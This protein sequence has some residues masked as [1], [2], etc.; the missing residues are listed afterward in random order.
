MNYLWKKLLFIA[1]LS[2]WLPV[3]S[4]VMAVPVQAAEG[5]V[6]GVHI[7]HPSELDAA[8]ELFQL[9]KADPNQWHYVT[10]PLSLNDLE[11]ND[12]WQRFFT[13]AK[14]RQIIPLVRLTTRFEDGAWVAPS[15]RD[16]TKLVSFL[17]K[18]DWPTDQRH[19]I[20]FNE[21]NHSKEWGNHLSPAE[22]AEV[23][24]FTAQWAK[25]ENKGFVV[26]PAAMDL[27][28]P[29]GK[30]TMEAFTYLDGM[31]AADPEIFSVV[32]IWN[33]HSYPNPGFS[34]A[35]TRVAQNSLRGFEY[36]L[37]YVKA[38]SGRDLEVFITET[39]WVENAATRRWLESYYRY[40]A[41]HIWSDPRVK[42]VTP[43]VLKG[44]PGPFS[45]F[46]LLDR[47][48]QPTRQYSAFKTALQA[49]P[50]GS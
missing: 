47:N 41:Q 16:I 48:N 46:S 25:T 10:I 14:R 20:V 44:D 45:A 5:Q 50:F 27:A 9:D 38:K 40:A 17:S 18:L 31:V 12:E 42:G 8:D 26:M 2:L 28:A 22:Y 1:L 33:S 13:E 6:L 24:R 36:E 11:K 37:K 30:Q 32:D 3:A 23:L 35:P 43:F 15:R 4:L 34:A 39:G 49:V 19:I 29:N 21:V 7:L